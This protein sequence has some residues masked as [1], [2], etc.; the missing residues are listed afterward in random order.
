MHQ[1]GGDDGG[2]VWTLT[3]QRKMGE[4]LWMGTGLLQSPT[5]PQI[6]CPAWFGVGGGQGLALYMHTHMYEPYGVYTLQN[7]GVHCSH[8]DAAES[9][10]GAG[11][12]GVR[13]RVR[14]GGRGRLQLASQ[15]EEEAAAICCTGESRGR[16][17][18]S[19][20][21][22]YHCGARQNRR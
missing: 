6:L 19:P 18:W 5:P 14:G 16:G 21:P 8:A 22:R 15:V 12:G 4:F 11:G 10:Y 9:E 1:D 13:H 17:L 20:Y 7:R 2:C 3:Q